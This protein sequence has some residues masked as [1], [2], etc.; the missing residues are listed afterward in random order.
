M[1]ELRPIGFV[2]SPFE[3]PKEVPHRPLDPALARGTLELYPEY[4]EG[5]S[6]LAGFSHVVVVSYLHL[7]KDHAL[8]V[9]PRLDQTHRGLFATRSPNRPNPIGISILGLE[10]IDG[11]HIRVNCLDLVD[12]TPILD[13][14]PHIPTRFDEEEIKLGWL[15]GKIE[16]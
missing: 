2:H 13:I 8:R 7:G 11:C 10:K 4:E 12:G 5:L 3:K 15:E 6:D 16:E 1:L 14:K 9:K